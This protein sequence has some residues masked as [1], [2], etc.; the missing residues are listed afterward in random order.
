MYCTDKNELIILFLILSTHRTVNK[1]MSMS[2]KVTSMMDNMDMDEYSG[3]Q[4]NDHTRHLHECC[5][6]KM[7]AYLVDMIRAGAHSAWWGV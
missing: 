7:D 5:W 2:G 6:S 4:D 1:V 3:D